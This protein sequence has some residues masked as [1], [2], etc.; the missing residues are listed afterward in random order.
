ME[1]RKET[2]LILFIHLSIHLF[3]VSW[4]KKAWL[5]ELNTLKSPIEDLICTCVYIWTNMGVEVEVDVPMSFYGMPV[6]VD[7][8]IKSFLSKNIKKNVRTK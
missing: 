8:F 3:I 7:V 1:R 5:R 2:Y 4:L 6:L